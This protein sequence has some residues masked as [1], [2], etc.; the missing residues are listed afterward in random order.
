MGPTRVEVAPRGERQ[1]LEKALEACTFQA[2]MDSGLGYHESRRCSRDTY[3]DSYQEVYQ[4][5]KVKTREVENPY[6]AGYA[7]TSGERASVLKLFQDAGYPCNVNS[8]VGPARERAAQHHPLPSKNGT[9]KTTL[10]ATRGG[11]ALA[12]TCGNWVGQKYRGTSLIGNSAP[13]GP[14]Q[15]QHP[16]SGL[17]RDF[18]PILGKKTSTSSLESPICPHGTDFSN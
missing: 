1:H 5:T 8:T 14:Y 7:L 6:Q 16:L 11:Y 15:G 13:L 17:P 18:G 3:P 12:L 10:L 9:L 2:V 4:C